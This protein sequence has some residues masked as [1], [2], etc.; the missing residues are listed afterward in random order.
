MS[1]RHFDATE[2]AEL[3]AKIDQ[4]KRRLPLPRLMEKLGLGEHAKKEAHCLWHDDQ[5]PSFSVFKGDD[6]FWHW[7]CFTG[8][9]G[10]DEIMF[11]RKLKGLSLPEAMSLYLEMAGFP[12]SSNSKSHELPK[13]HECHEFLELPKSLVFPVSPVSEGQS[14]AVQAVNGELETELKELA[15]R[16]AC[17][18]NTRPEDNSWQLARD[19]KAVAKRIGRKLSAAELMLPFDEWHRLSEPF[20]E[21]EKSRDYYWMR[22]LA[23]LQ[24]VRVPTG[25][26]TLSEA[27]QYVS[28]LT[29]NG[30]PVIPGC[31]EALAAR[32]IAALH[33]ELAR[34][35]KKKK[36]Q[37]FLSYRDAAGACEGLSHQDAHTITFGLATLGVIDFVNKGKAGLNSGQAAEFIYLLPETEVAKCSNVRRSPT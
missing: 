37:Y 35:S 22:F 14:N 19:L 12:A 30:L 25:E 9:G 32:K 6:G 20:L 7:N 31:G 36:K 17:M 8:C 3:R 28:T 16:N 21:A 10:G 27:V 13:S 34:R 15:A 24:K 26:G 11:L 29:E 1:G 5:H 4:A 23:Q 2:N 18:G 33:R